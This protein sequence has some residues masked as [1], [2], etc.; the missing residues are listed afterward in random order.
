MEN[1]C[2]QGNGVDTR[3]TC[4]NHWLDLLI[5]SRQTA[6]V[7]KILSCFVSWR[8]MHYDLYC[9]NMRCCIF[10]AIRVGRLCIS[11]MHPVSGNRNRTAG[12]RTLHRPNAPRWRWN[13]VCA[14]RL[15]CALRHCKF[16]DLR[17]K[18]EMQITANHGGVSR[19]HSFAHMLLF[20]CASTTVGNA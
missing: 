6:C 15:V 11:V 3:C 17:K 4:Q 20:Q 13:I 1:G 19:E 5:R 9:K 7:V 2:V 16:D 8:V 10:D 12:V 18:L 14:A